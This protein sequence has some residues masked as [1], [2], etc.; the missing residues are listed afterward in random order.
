M[1]TKTKRIL[2]YLLE[3]IMVA[4]GVFLGIFVSEWRAEKEIQKDVKKS[5]NL[6]LEELSSNSDNLGRT[7]SYHELIRVNLD[8]TISNLTKEDFQKPYFSDRKFILMKIPGWT[9]IRL[10]NLENI[11]YESAKIGGIFQEL[12]VETI[13]LISRAYNHQEFYK[14]ISKSTL[15]KLIAIDSNTK[16]SDVIGIIQLLTSDVLDTERSLKNSLDNTIEQLKTN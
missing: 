7:I 12:D 2:K 5:I 3:V 14:D 9:G 11:A 10:N 8:S 4:F 13:Q 15:E 1:G 6:M 16:N